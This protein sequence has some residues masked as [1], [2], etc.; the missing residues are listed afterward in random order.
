MSQALKLKKLT[1][2]GF[3]KDYTINFKEGLNFIS[4]PISTGKS[5][6]LEMVNYALGSKKHKD[7]IEVK[8]SC[9]DVELEVWL[10]GEL[11]KIS[12]PLFNFDKSIKLYKWDTVLGKFNDEFEI[13]EVGSPQESNSLSYFLLE[14]LGVPEITISN[15]AF[16]FRDLFKYSYVSQ[17]E[18]DSENLLD[19]R[20]YTIAFKRKPTLEIIFNSLDH[21]LQSLKELRKTKKEDLDKFYDKKFA[22]LSFLQSVNLFGNIGDYNEQWKTITTSIS[23]KQE[24]LNDLKNQ[25]KIKDDR[26]RALEAKMF[27]IRR[28]INSYDEGKEELRRYIEKLI[29]LRNQYQIEVVKLDYLILANGKFQKVEFEK[30]PVCL[31]EIHSEKEHDKCYLCGNSL[32]ELSQEE[33]QAIKL[34]RKRIGAKL[35]QLVEFIELKQTEIRDFDNKIKSNQESLNSINEKINNI[36]SVYVSPYISKVEELNQA[37]GELREHLKK[38]NENVKIQKEF[39]QIA[40]EITSEELKLQQ[41]IEDIKK[42]E[43]ENIGSDKIFAELSKT[44]DNTLKA[45]DFPKL[46]NA[47]IDSSSYIPYVRGIRYNDLGSLGAVTLITVAYFLS[48]LKISIQLKKTYHPG[49]LLF[50]SISSNLGRD[51]YTTEDEFK[52]DKIFKSMVK[53]FVDFSQ[54]NKEQVQIIIIN[55]GYTADVNKEDI[56]VEFDGIGTKGLPYGL[57]DDMVK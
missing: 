3:R 22:I 14:K 24:E 13:L 4:G 36:Q 42:L 57:I 5:T 37:I 32:T 6:I 39:S 54:K 9:T 27:L 30:C 45:F 40:D 17:P 43:E 28:E 50:D 20:N 38:I 12:R 44:F 55:N 11:F 31:G 35:N 53:H 29:L 1:L 2:K 47:Y 19:E 15:Q 56:I 34:E 51:S 23:E 26:S 49:L 16:S 8:A 48:I 41:L 25:S 33:E 21:F 7:Y 10:K 52:D 46:S 18:I